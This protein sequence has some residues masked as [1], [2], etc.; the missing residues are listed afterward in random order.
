MKYLLSGEQM[1]LCDYYT[2]NVLGVPS[3]VLM[4]RA[5]LSVVE[6]MYN[7]EFDMRNVVVV[8][9]SGNNG[10]DGFAI[11]RILKERGANVIIYFAGREAS[12]TDSAREQLSIAINYRIKVINSGLGIKSDEIYDIRDLNPTTIVDAMFGV[13]LNRELSEPYRRLVMQMN[14]LKDSG[15]KIVS[16][17]IPSG[18]HADNGHI[19]GDAV[20]A[21][22]TVAFAFEKLGHVFYPGRAYAGKLV[23]KDIGITELSLKG[24]NEERRRFRD[25]S[26]NNL[27]TMLE[28]KDIISIK[29]PAY[30][31]KGTFGKVLLIVGSSKMGGAALLAAKACM[32]SGAGMIQVFTHEKNYGF[33]IESLPEA[34]ITTYSDYDEQNYLSDEV[35]KSGVNL[36]LEAALAWCDCIGIGPGLSTSYFAYEL[37]KYTFTRS[38]KPLVLDADAINMLS[39]ATYLLKEANKNGREVI[40]TPHIGEYCRLTGISKENVVN[41]ILEEARISADRFGVICVLKDAR[42]VVADPFSN[43]RINTSGNSGMATAGSGD[44]LFGIIC[45]FKA[46][47]MTGFEAASY[48]VYLHG[49]SGDMA[50]KRFGEH[51]MLA[52]NIIDGMSELLN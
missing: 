49:R 43:A 24:L 17:D 7:N 18:I 27:C 34:I 41:N 26:M 19:M 33:I 32:K 12:L 15:S 30:S 2:S 38:N 11:A 44:V 1:K 31:N 51:G 40:I 37:L 45:G 35:I 13:G 14:I 10:G 52:G 8:C 29:R 21:D 36:K 47:G 5:A 50:A 23:V 48:G 25:K 9:G 42:T 39:E 22:L 20:R 6:E 4:E 28:D 3:I 46:Q 16:V